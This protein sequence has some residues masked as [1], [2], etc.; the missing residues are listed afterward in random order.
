MFGNGYDFKRDFTTL[1]KDFDIKLV[2]TSVKNP[3]YNYPVEQL[4]QVILNM[5]VTKD[6]DNK[7]FDYIDPW[8]ETLAYIAWAIRASYQC[9][10]M[11]T[12]GKA[13]F[14]RDMLFNLASVVDWRVATAA[15]QRQVDIDNFRENAK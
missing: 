1:I 13:V 2:L 10:I 12:P 14:D 9:T 4:H 15:K 3:Q 8:G 6:P 11:A 7:L 5:L